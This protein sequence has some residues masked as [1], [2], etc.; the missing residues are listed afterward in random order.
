MA[1]N[2]KKQYFRVKLPNS[3]SEEE[4]ERTFWNILSRTDAPRVMYGA[5]LHVSKNGS[6]FPTV[7]TANTLS[8]E[9]KAYIKSGWNLNNLPNLS[10]SV[11]RFIRGDVSGMK[12]PWLYVGMCFST[13]C[14][15]I[16]D[17]W[18][19]SINYLHFGEAKSWYGV[20]ASQAGREL[21]IN[22]CVFV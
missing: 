22:C 1:D 9:E 17:H 7:K 12:I 14:W 3:V 19:A 2:F 4:V 10:D 20:P 15:H 13:F 21:S 5:D 16:E 18:T 6:G 11:L 8:E